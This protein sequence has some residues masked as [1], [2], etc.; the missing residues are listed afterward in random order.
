MDDRPTPDLS[1][2]ARAA[3]AGLLDTAAHVQRG[4]EWLAGLIERLVPDHP[5]HTG[6]QDVPQITMVAD[7][8]VTW[9]GTHDGMLIGTDPACQVRLD[10][11]SVQPRHARVYL[12][13][14]YGWRVESLGGSVL[15]S[16]R[17]SQVLS[18]LTPGTRIVVGTVALDFDLAEAR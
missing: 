10:D 1:A 8:D 13:P 3:C 18:P 2:L 12:D 16:G 17:P 6:G 4:A 5:D 11:P 9:V 15:R 14:G 7:P